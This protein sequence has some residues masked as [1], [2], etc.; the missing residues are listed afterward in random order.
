MGKTLSKTKPTNYHWPMIPR[1]LRVVLGLFI[2]ACAALWILSTKLQGIP[3]AAWQVQLNAE[4]WL[5]MVLLMPLN[6]TLEVI[7][8]AELMPYGRMASRWREV[9]YGVS[10]S[11]IGPLKLGAAVGRVSAVRP[12]YRG[13]ALRAFAT[14]SVSQWWCTVTA[15]GIAFLALGHVQF[16]L[17]ILGFSAI[18]LSLYFGWTPTFWNLLS[19]SKLTGD[20]RMARHIPSIRRSRALTFSIARFVVMLTQFVL[21]L[22]AFGHL[23][24]FDSLE[25]LISQASGASLTWGLTAMVPIPVLGDIGIREA[26]A[27]MT[28][29]APK[30]EDITA[31]VCATLSLWF[32]NLIV[33]ALIGLIWQS[34][35][36]RATE[37]K[38]K[39]QA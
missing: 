25:R 19:R 21:A 8:W 12:K 11:L 18:A 4:P 38:A 22:N 37:Q 6:W 39:L 17:L 36:F 5:L 1:P 28:L 23:K 10:W 15:T 33:P 14:A 24:G 29:P 2:P 16:A 26:A 34:N 13:Q 30:A 9:L 20:W 7:K 31:I 3:E 35:D 27:L 32:I